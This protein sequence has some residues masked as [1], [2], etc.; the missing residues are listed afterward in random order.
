MSRRSHPPRPSWPPGG[1][2]GRLLTAVRRDVAG[3]NYGT[4]HAPAVSAVVM[5]A[6]AVAA[7]LTWRA[8]T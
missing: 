3:P 8:G 4:T 5:S 7:A 1:V 6:A 2:A